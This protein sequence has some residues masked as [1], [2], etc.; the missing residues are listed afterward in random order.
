MDALFFFFKTVSFWISCHIFKTMSFWFLIHL[1]DVVLFCIEK[2][3]I[4][5]EMTSFYLLQRRN[6]VVSATFK[7]QKEERVPRFQIS[8]CRGEGEGEGEGDWGGGVGSHLV[9]ASSD[10]DG[11][12]RLS[13]WSEVGDDD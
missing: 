11:D 9:P 6:N 7:S 12:W 3:L 8:I 4:N 13:F 1:N 10:G 5:N 2:K